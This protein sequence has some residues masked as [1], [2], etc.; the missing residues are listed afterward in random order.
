MA[1]SRS[2]KGR[3]SSRSGGTRRNPE[4]NPSGMSTGLIALGAAVAAAAVTTVIM[5]NRRN[6]A[7]QA[8][9]MIGDLGDL[10]GGTTEPPDSTLFAR[11]RMNPAARPMRPRSVG[12][13]AWYGGVQRMPN[14]GV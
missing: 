4:E 5:V 2:K 8:C 3:G 7:L 11:R 6:M 1:K 10:G 13:A 9:G 14:G 12:A